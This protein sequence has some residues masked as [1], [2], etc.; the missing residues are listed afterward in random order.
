MPSGA[1]RYSQP[2]LPAARA[3]T[4]Y[5]TTIEPT[6]IW[7]RRV[8]LMS[9]QRS[10]TGPPRSPRRS[11]STLTV[12]SP[13]PRQCSRGRDGAA[14]RPLG[15]AV[16]RPALPLVRLDIGP[17]FAV[18]RRDRVRVPADLSEVVGHRVLGLTPPP[19]P[20]R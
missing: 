17:L 13:L 1:L 19:Q 12:L 2:W 11:V 18:V 5:T 8:P 6:T 9:R 7:A 3:Q 15:D 10:A 20:V 14:G 16:L 4:R